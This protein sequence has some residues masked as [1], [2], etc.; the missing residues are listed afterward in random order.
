MSR[1]AAP[2]SATLGGGPAE[3][4][5]AR[6]AG[7]SGDTGDRRGLVLALD[8]GSPVVSVAVGAG[9]LAL[10]A[11]AVALQRSSTQLLALAAEVLAAAGARPA[12]LAGVVALAGPGSF[13]G[14]RVGLA[15][16]LGLVQGLGVPAQ[17]LPSLQALAAASGAPPGTLVIAA[18]DALRGEWSAQA[19]RA[20]PV[21]RPLGEM[22]LV[23]AGE[24]LRRLLPEAASPD[25]VETP[26]IVAFGVSA[27][28]C[29]GDAAGGRVRFREAP[30]LA[31]AALR[32]AAG[33]PRA[34]WRTASLAAPIYS[35]PPA[36]T[37][38]KARSKTRS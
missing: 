9:G 10:A 18:V 22:T 27:L 32:L 25:E 1:S 15:T 33:L 12:D 4:R 13:T 38:P 34:R 28:A 17:A 24:L 30:P 7:D 11:R 21:P 37:A 36:T 6:D 14:L 29:G 16:A 5:D 2:G 26:E 8:A 31:P 19:F 23:P 3:A 35:R 20:G